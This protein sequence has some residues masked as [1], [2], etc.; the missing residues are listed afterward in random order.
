MR[1]RLSRGR[2][3]CCTLPPLRPRGSRVSPAPCC[4]THTHPPRAARAGELPL[5]KWRTFN[6]PELMPKYLRFAER[7]A[8]ELGVLDELAAFDQ[9]AAAFPNPTPV[10]AAT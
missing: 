6:A 3:A 7:A 4:R 10:Y 8:R 5:R 2:H 9:A 1:S